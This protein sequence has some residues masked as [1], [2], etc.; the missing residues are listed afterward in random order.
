[1]DTFSSPSAVVDDETVRIHL[2][3]QFSKSIK[4]I[5]L[6]IVAWPQN[7]FFAGDEAHK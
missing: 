7:P 4:K 6:I 2:A 3:C 1:M 5:K